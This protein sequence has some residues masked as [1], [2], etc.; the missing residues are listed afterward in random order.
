ML[1]FDRFG[2]K[3][4][5]FMQAVV[6]DVEANVIA[7]VVNVLDPGKEVDGALDTVASSG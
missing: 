3:T 6:N 5:K 1:I 2:G 7:V 4:V